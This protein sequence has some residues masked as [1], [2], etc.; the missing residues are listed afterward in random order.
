MRILVAEDSVLFREGLVR[1]LAELGHEVVGAVGD[2]EAL[3]AAVDKDAPELVVSDIRMP[4]HL[5]SD[6]ASAA[7]AIRRRHPM[8]ALVLLSQH[9]EMRHCRELV[10]TARFG[11][12]LK[13][14]VLDL[15]EFDEALRRVATGGTALDPVVV[16]AL[17]RDSTRTSALDTLTEREREVLAL[18]AQGHSN[19]AGAAAL[20]LPDRTVE[21]HMRS[22]FLKLGIQDDSGTHRRVRAVIAFLEA[23]S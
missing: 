14:R 23:G 21:A 2:A 13:D 18:V 1:V 5:E 11:Y 15:Q 10:G 19:A 7:S 6:G 16:Q 9:I 3:L 12:L 20:Y 17:V 8:T 22:V 4:P